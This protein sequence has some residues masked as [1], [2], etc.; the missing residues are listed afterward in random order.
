MCRHAIHRAVD[1]LGRRRGGGA[2]CLVALLALA[3]AGTRA[4]A[5]PAADAVGIEARLVG[6]LFVD[7][8]NQLIDLG[9]LIAPTAFSI[10]ADGSDAADPDQ[11]V[12][13]FAIRSPRTRL[14]LQILYEPLTRAGT[15]DVVHIGAPDGPALCWS[16]EGPE[17]PGE[18]TCDL[19]GG[20]DTDLP[21]ACIQGG[22]ENWAF[23]GY[24]VTVDPG[25]SPGVYENDRAIVLV[26]EQMLG[27][28]GGPCS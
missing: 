26:A 9:Q 17:G 18:W 28:G 8:R 10:A 14:R 11:D 7:A 2:F 5:Q 15:S 1:I 12:A 4:E 3:T 19:L 25:T 20:T 13:S 21:R 16:R 6:E 23:V 24:S 27:G 22:H